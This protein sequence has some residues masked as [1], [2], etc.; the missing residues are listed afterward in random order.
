[1]GVFSFCKFRYIFN[2]KIPKRL[3]V[4]SEGMSRAQLVH[5]MSDGMKDDL[6]NEVEAE[7]DQFQW[8][9]AR[10]AVV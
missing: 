9:K 7:E 2:K 8:E 3:P 4:R 1:L 5:H 6:E 10:L